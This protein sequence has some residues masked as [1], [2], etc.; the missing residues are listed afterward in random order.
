[1]TKS[2]VSY[3]GF[4][5]RNRLPLNELEKYYCNRRL[6]KY[7][8]GK[9][10]RGIF[11][12]KIMHTPII[13]CLKLYHHICVRK[14]RIIY[15]NSE[16]KK[17]AIY[18]A[19]HIG[20]DDIEYIMDAISEHTYLFWGDP[21]ELYRSFAG[22]LLDLNGCVICDTKCKSDRF[23]AKET[24]IKLLMTGE[25]LLIFP[26]GV[27]NTSE[28][29]LVNYLFPGVAEMAIRTKAD[30]IPIAIERT[31]KG[32]DVAI[33]KNIH[34]LLYDMDDKWQLV[35]K[36]RDD[37]ATLKWDVLEASGVHKRTEI[38]ENYSEVFKNNILEDARGIAD[39]EGF[40][41]QEFHPQNTIED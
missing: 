17:P 3:I 27:W 2:K 7:E 22:A 36:I 16:K 6:E 12:R 13:K 29:K 41:S 21:Q 40:K 20:W 38:P 24:A 39:W 10:I 9:S 37:M 25:N 1:M 11:L 28:N 15:D 18:A 8:S 19:T 35:Q 14:L 31:K 33:G 32:F 30:I 5:K 4:I 23:V 26:E 34:S